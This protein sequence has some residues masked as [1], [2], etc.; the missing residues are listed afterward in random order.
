M[1][2]FIS[3]IFISALEEFVIQLFTVFVPPWD[4]ILS[5]ASRDIVH[6]CSD[7]CSY[8]EFEIFGLRRDPPYDPIQ[9]CGKNDP[10]C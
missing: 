2:H 1:Q 5:I 9:L 3:N 7:D 10:V 8:E 6:G 4:L